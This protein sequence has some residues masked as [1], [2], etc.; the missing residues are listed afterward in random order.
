MSVSAADFRQSDAE[1]AAAVADVWDKFANTASDESVEAT[2][3]ALKA[4]GHSVRS[5][6]YPSNDVHYFYCILKL[7]GRPSFSTRKRRL[8]PPSLTLFLQVFL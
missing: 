5:S 8:L 1:A 7:I 3:A 6:L 2:V 4:K